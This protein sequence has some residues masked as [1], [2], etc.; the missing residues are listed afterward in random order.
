MT[1]HDKA[2]LPQRKQPVHITPIER[3]NQPVILFVTIAVQPRG[4]HLANDLF[5]KVF[6]EACIDAD[7]WSVGKYMIMPDHVH[8]FCRPAVFPVVNLL[9]WVQYLKERITKRLAVAKEKSG[10]RTCGEPQDPQS[11]AQGCSGLSPIY[12]KWQPGC[13]DTQ[14]RDGDHYRDKWLYVQQNPVRAELVSMAEEWPFQG[15]VHV[16]RW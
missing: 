10:G 8:L 12:W 9:R 3:P 5:H 4:Y 2:K 7:R 11:G 16:L 14:I 6:C 1:T 15:E 13:W